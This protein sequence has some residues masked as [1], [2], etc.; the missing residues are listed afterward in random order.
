MDTILSR[1]LESKSYDQRMH[2]L[3]V[4]YRTVRQQ[5]DAI[6]QRN[7]I[8]GE[9]KIREQLT[10]Q[11]CRDEGNNKIPWMRIAIAS[12]IFIFTKSAVYHVYILSDKHFI[13][14]NKKI[15]SH[16]RM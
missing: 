4:L 8:L 10:S 6:L 1:M 3:Q 7:A 13:D 9:N 11:P 14:K 2:I 12:S 16:S 5:F 15:I